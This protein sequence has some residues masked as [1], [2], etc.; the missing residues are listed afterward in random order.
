MSL[1][2]RVA[3]LEQAV[4]PPPPLQPLVVECRRVGDDGES[5]PPG[6]YNDGAPGSMCRTVVYEGDEPDEKVLAQF[7]PKR[8]PGPLFVR[9][10][11]SVVEPPADRL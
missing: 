1:R 10:E 8:G 9:F 2:H 11:P 5:R 7:R 4:A 3:K 6:V